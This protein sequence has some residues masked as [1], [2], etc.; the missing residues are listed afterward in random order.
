VSS[1]RSQLFHK[2]ST[3]QLGCI[4][5]ALDM[6]WEEKFNATD[7]NLVEIRP[8]YTLL[9]IARRELQERPAAAHRDAE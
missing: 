3:D 8:T 4:V 1:K 7:A 9:N 6:L 5:I 2:L